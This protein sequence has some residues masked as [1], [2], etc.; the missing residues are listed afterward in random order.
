MRQFLKTY[1]A[2]TTGTMAGRDD[3]YPYTKLQLLKDMNEV[4]KC[5]GT[6]KD[7]QYYVVEAVNPTEFEKELQKAKE[8]IVEEK[9]KAERD[10]KIKE[11]ERL[12]AE[13]G[14]E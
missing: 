12:K 11:L 1:T 8:Q 2:L 5:H 13:L 9:K 14:E 7:E 4:A 3:G 6:K 10:K